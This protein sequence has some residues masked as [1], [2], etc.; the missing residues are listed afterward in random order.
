MNRPPI[1]TEREI[2]IINNA[3]D[4]YITNEILFVS[5]IIGCYDDFDLDIENAEYINGLYCEI[6]D[7]KSKIHM[8]IE[9]S[10]EINAR[11]KMLN[12]ILSETE[13]DEDE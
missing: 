12:K 6:V 11:L 2:N 4:S 1:F 10:E 13:V 3:L 8:P 7:I 9:L 5:D